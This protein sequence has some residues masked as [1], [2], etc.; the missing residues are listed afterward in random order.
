[1]SFIEEIG[2]V[3]RIKVY[4]KPH[5]NVEQFSIEGDELVFYTTEPPTQGRANASLI[6][7][8]SKT[9]NVPRSSLSIVHGAR[10]RL[11]VVEVRGEKAENVKSKLL[12]AAKRL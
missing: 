6:R 7:K 10:D 4:V 5:S 9:L 2:N 11:K 3:V 12:D 1:M 8:L